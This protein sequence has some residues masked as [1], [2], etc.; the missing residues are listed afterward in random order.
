MCLMNLFMIERFLYVILIFLIHLRN[1]I[2][3]FY[4]YCLFDAVISILAIVI[5]LYF[6]FIDMILLSSYIA[7]WPNEFIPQMIISIIWL[8]LITLIDR[9]FVCFFI[10]VTFAYLLHFELVIFSL[11]NLLN[12]LIFVWVFYFNSLLVIFQMLFDFFV[13][14]FIVVFPFR[15]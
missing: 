12:Y 15:S 4:S 9:M 2:C 10:Q 8:C 11:F 1:L 6:R 3:L 13:T 14:L 5:E 7:F